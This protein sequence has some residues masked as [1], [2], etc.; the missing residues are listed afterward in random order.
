MLEGCRLRGV[1]A[2]Y[3]DLPTDQTITDY[4]TALPNPSDPTSPNPVI[5]ADVAGT[6]KTFTVPAGQR[7]VLDLVTAGRDPA[8]FPDPNVVKPDRPLDSYIHFGWGPHACAGL[9]LSR[10]AQT[11][12]FK[13]IVG[14][15][16]LKRAPGGRGTL[17][18]MPVR[19][20]DGQLGIGDK[21]SVAEEWTGLR[22]YMTPDQ[23]GIWPV[24]STMKVRWTE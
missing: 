21:D 6:T 3:R 19:V 1:V 20:W 9:D 16:E 18:S 15:K 10:V 23:G 13:A 8:H 2:L 14:H 11:A 5:N 17:K 4:P 22:V 7:I 24:P 12:L